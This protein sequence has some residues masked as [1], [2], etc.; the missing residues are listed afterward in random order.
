MSV[1][2]FALLLPLGLAFAGTGTIDVSKQWRFQPDPQD[3]GT[4]Q[5][6]QA[7]DFNSEHWPLVDVGAP[8]E[9]QGFPEVNGTAWYRRSVEIPRNWEGRRVWLVVGG[10]DDECTIFCN[11]TRVNSF[12]RRDSN[13]VHYVPLMA[14]LED[15]LRFGE[16]NV[17]A[18]QV[19]DWGAGGGLSERPCILTTEF[20]HVPRD[21]IF[22][23][24]TEYDAR[25]LIVDVN[26][27]GLGNA[28][29]E[30]TL[31][32][33]LRAADT[34]LPV[35]RRSEVLS[36]SSLAESFVFDLAGVR[37]GDDFWVHVTPRQAGGAVLAG[38]ESEQRFRWPEVPRWRGRQG[39]ARVLNNF[40]T[41]LLCIS[42]VPEETAS[43][44][45]SNPREG[46]VLFSLA[47][48]RKGNAEPQVILKGR[49]DR[50]K[51]RIHPLHG[52][53]EAMRFMS[54]GGH[55]LRV[56]Q[57]AGMDLEV[58]A[59]PEIGFCEYPT[60][61]SISAYGR[62]DAAYYQCYVLPDVNML[63]THATVAEDEL[64]DWVDE[65]RRWIGRAQLPG[66][67]EPDPPS[68]DSVFQVWATNP[69]SAN[70]YYNG[71]MVDE[72]VWGDVAH[73]RAWEDALR[74]LDATRDFS[75]KTFYAWCVHLFRQQSG[76]RFIRAIAELDHCFSWERYMHEQP[77]LEALQDHLRRDM[78]EPF[79]EWKRE[80][81]GIERR[82]LVCLGYLDAP[83][84]SFDMNPGVSYR[85]L[86][87]MQMHMLAT[88]P[89]FWGLRGVMA[90]T[91]HLADE[92]TLRFTQQLYR[93][94]CIEGRRERF[95]SDPYVLPHLKNPDFA[96]GLSGWRV[97]PAETN[98]D[99]IVAERQPRFGW[100][101]GRYFLTGEGDSYCRMTR[102]AKGLNC[103]S[104][105]ITSLEPGRLYS[106]KLISADL[107][108]LDTEQTLPLSIEITGAERI[109]ELSFQ[110]PYQ[111]RTV[112]QMRASGVA[113][114]VHM[115][116][117]RVVF[118]PAAQTAE[119]AISDW[120]SPT[121]PGELI[122]QE[123]AF[124]FVQI[125]PFVEK[126]D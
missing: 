73:Y 25:R 124:N 67:A 103:V 112:E 55:V 39:K 95:C 38:I 69:G 97:K 43:Y 77:T 90:F 114:P 118:R 85:M 3:A 89:T 4:V 22:Q 19:I 108:H 6:W 70:R 31:D 2:T 34:R 119:L 41:E 44:A 47:G 56:D 18:I 1:F 58:R 116:M 65:G 46:W 75:D 62:Y 61:P 109:E 60:E 91:A 8:W 11:G 33:E 123:L 27:A 59:I 14:P 113:Q 57:A 50:L 83:P 107:Q 79:E 15:Y 52:G 78:Q 121:D 72:F 126:N 96:E 42:P 76:L 29:P 104:Q 40:V 115:N 117:H 16:S 23:Y 49:P 99:S 17:I 53:F 81:P 84:V 51:W 88:E 82:V 87:D 86:L 12:G 93:H 74:R 122:G 21:S 105:T 125:E 5:Q 28:R 36:T 48:Q 45:F 37:S 10:A 71:I 102:S 32:I 80:W 26:V 98:P 13:P 111:A 100:M 101:Q 66:L 30:T 94:Y 7:T 9:E 106:L 35:M 63:I 24:V 64:R 110:C 120:Q 92:E 68:S 20:K 54:K